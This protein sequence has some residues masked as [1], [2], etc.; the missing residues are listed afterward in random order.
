ML[1]MKLYTWFYGKLE[2]QD[3]FGNQYYTSRRPKDNQHRQRR[4]VMYKGLDEASKVP[5]EWHGWL[6]HIVDTSPSANPP[7]R[8]QWQKPHLPNLTGTLYAYHPQGRT[9]NRP[10]AIGDY[11]AWAPKTQGKAT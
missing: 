4:W 1:G 6:H 8:Y 11:Q 5:A 10:A 7:N 9:G 2:G 3:I